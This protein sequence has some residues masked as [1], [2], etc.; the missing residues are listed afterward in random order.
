MSVEAHSA[1][2]V[3]VG[4]SSDEGQQP[5]SDTTDLKHAASLL[6][7]IG[8][9]SYF[10]ATGTS[11]C[12]QGM[13]IINEAD[14]QAAA[15]SMGATYANSGNWQHLPRG[16]ITMI[17]VFQGTFQ[18]QPSLKSP[19]CRLYTFRKWGGFRNILFQHAHSRR[20]QF[21]VPPNVQAG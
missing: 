21:H 4:G 15:E 20:S 12:S 1:N 5:K 6:L 10:E 8:V 18:L 16:T 7:Q 13:E 17:P 2:D 3:E 9:G 11:S 19:R 14:C